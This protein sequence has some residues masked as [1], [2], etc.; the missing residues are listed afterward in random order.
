MENVLDNVDIIMLPIS[1][2]QGNKANKREEFDRNG[3][4]IN[5]LPS[6]RLA[7]LGSMKTISKAAT[8]GFDA[9]KREALA[10]CSKHGVKFGD[11]YAVPKESTPNICAHLAEIKLR[12]YEEKR[13][14][15]SNYDSYTEEWIMSNDASWR[16]TIR[17][18]LDPVAKVA[19][20]LSFNFCAYR[21]NQV[22]GMADELNG[23]HE[24]TGGLY[25]QLQKEIR[26]MAQGAL[27]SSYLGKLAV[28]KRALR[29]L[30]SIST[31]LTGMS[32]L[33]EEIGGLVLEI[34]EN[35]TSAV[36]SINR[37]KDCVL[38]GA[39]LHQT[40]GL[41]TKI[42]NIGLDIAMPEEPEDVTEA[43]EEDF[44]TNTLLEQEVAPA[45]KI[46]AISL[47]DF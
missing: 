26:Q 38:T 2:W 21:I 33:H 32:F 46:N 18:S 44:D 24:E 13:E 23:L 22:E 19:S 35:M 37:S 7:S 10:I 40:V 3:I 6:D 15:L 17:R 14:F 45:A 8:K 39:E 16:E 27:K 9:L 28:T 30:S 11:G 36:N 12:F 5:R 1:L 29:P 42:A 25:A 20:C 41:L 47:W 34:H 43:I 31:K 4:N